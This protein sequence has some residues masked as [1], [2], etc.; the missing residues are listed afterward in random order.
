MPE[1]AGF[2][3]FIRNT[4]GVSADVLPDDDPSVNLAW[5]MSMDWVNGQLA[6]ISP[7]LY[8][9]AVY[10]LAASFLINFG[11]E[12]VFGE[13][14]KTL[15]TNNFTAGVISASA[16]ESTSQT[17]VVSDAF[18]NLSLADLQQLK[19]PYGRWYL[20]IAQQYGD[21]WGLS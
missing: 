16:D 4:M 6:C 1:L 15:G 8:S 19:D 21:L 20:A 9:Q 3:L 11:P 5:S 18:K 12:A 13:L 17:R 14:R 10:N 2:I 7:V